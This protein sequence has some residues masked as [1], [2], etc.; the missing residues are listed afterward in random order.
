MARIVQKRKNDSSCP[1]MSGEGESKDD[2]AV[3]KRGETPG[4][5]KNL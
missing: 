2:I 3:K 5:S 1:T 4:E